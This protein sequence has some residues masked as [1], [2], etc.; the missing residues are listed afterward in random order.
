MKDTTKKYKYKNFV[1]TK[2]IKKLLNVELSEKDKEKLKKIY[3]NY[4]VENNNR[5][6]EYIIKDIY[7]LLEK[8]KL[9]TKDLANIY[10][11]NIRTVQIWLKELGLNR[12]KS[13][14]KKTLKVTGV[15]KIISKR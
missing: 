10:K 7:I 4:K 2:E 1:Y 15:R 5:N 8:Q 11:V 3:N 9:N 14:A 12:S 13:K 6:Y